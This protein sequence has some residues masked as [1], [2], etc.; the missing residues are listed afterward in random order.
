[1]SRSFDHV[2]DE[3]DASRGGEARGAATA[4]DIAPLLTGGGPA[5]EVGIGTGV[6]AR[7]LR[8][9]GWSVVGVDLAPAMLR[10]ARDR[11]GSR[12]AVADAARLPFPDA[13]FADAYAVW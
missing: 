6:V 9:R 2:A 7:A 1:M 3:Y 11:V 13:A 8:E 4:A 5:L 10:R 12:V